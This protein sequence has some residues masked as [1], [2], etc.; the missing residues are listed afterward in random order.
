[1]QERETLV[2]NLIQAQNKI[3]ELEKQVQELKNELKAE[4]IAN[5]LMQAL[6]AK[7]QRIQEL[8]QRLAIMTDLMEQDLTSQVEF[9][10]RS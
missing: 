6:Q 9:P 2:Q 10:P 8:T 1:M 3:T 7:D 5:N 4:E